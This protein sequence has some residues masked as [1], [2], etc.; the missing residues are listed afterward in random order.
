MIQNDCCEID[1]EE[2]YYAHVKT[3]TIAPQVWFF[4]DDRIKIIN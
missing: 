2:R 1:K 3:E 4:T